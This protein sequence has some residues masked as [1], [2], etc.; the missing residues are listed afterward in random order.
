MSER[1]AWVEVDLDAYGH[2]LEEIKKCVQGGAKLCVVVK[3][4]AYGH[5]AIA[6]ARKAVEHGADYL[7]TAM[8]SEAMELRRAGFTEP[9]LI[10]GLSP[11]AAAHDIVKYDITQAVC[12]M[13]MAE[14]LSE[15]AVRQ[16]KKAKV[17]IKVD[18]GMARIGIYPEQAGAFAR[19]LKLQ[20]GLDVEGIFS[21]FAEADSKDKSYVKEQLS[22]F[23]KALD[24][25][26]ASGVHVRLRH[27]AESAAILEIPE[28]HFD[29]VRVG[30]IQYGLWP[31]DEVTHPIELRPVM[32]VKA[33]IAFLKEMQP[34]ETIGYG[35][36]YKV[37]RPS[38]IA[39]F[40]IGYA[41]GYLREMGG[42]ASVLIGEKRAPV[43]GRVCMDQFM[44]DV[45]DIPEAAIGTEAIVF[46]TPE[47]T[48]DEAASWL[49]TIN[50][51]I[52]CLMGSMRLPRVYKP[53]LNRC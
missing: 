28:A 6:C 38:R 1:D 39:T 47:L 40:P 12:T 34:G 20:P 14:A 45:T 17:H 30:V 46:G 35:R 24:L 8:L 5:G 41:D 22:R 32:C 50:Y 19:Q 7:A 25:V 44:V 2:N 18:T 10:L 11:I 49:G 27:I 21:H 31:S 33:R 26:E 52:V 36:A 42:K 15:E 4:D 53:E 9:I 13:E 29:M 23:N 16:N 48:A 51:E 37:T 43:V 3:A